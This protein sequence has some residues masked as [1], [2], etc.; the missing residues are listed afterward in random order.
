MSLR[1]VWETSQYNLYLILLVKSKKDVDERYVWSSKSLFTAY[2][3]Q[4]RPEKKKKI[5]LISSQNF[6]PFPSK[7]CILNWG[8]LTGT[9][10]IS[11][12]TYILSN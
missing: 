12:E 7:Q 6:D 11:I 3:K 9:P 8:P 10:W 1:K 4:I 2:K 5:S